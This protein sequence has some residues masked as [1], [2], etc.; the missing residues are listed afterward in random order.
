[1]SDKRPGR[2]WYCGEAKLRLDDP[3]E[4]VIPAALGGTLETY[5][6]C[7]ECNERAGREID[8]PFQNDWIVAQTKRL[9]DVVSSRKGASGRGRTGRSEAHRK[10]DPGTVVDIDRD[11]KPIVR[12][13][14]ERT[15]SGARISAR[16]REEAGRLRERLIKQLAAEGLQIQSEETGRDQFNEVEL[17]VKLDG[18]VWLRAAAKMVLASLSLSVDESWLDPDDAKQLRQWLWEEQPTHEDGSPASTSPEL[19]TDPERLVAPPPTH[20]ITI[21]SSATSNERVGVGIGLFGSLYV[22]GSVKIPPPLPDRCWVVVPGE[23]PRDLT[24][25]S[26][27]DEA[28]RRYI[29]QS[30]QGAGP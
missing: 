8:W 9:H 24:F 28:T 21:F 18:V 26:Y 2:C 3:P 12:S 20:L 14:I 25:Q 6:V 7:R 22:R 27:V 15:E 19:P 23:Q 13:N 11:W 10:G 4:H 5:R 16:S 29:E 30:E 17:K 1:M